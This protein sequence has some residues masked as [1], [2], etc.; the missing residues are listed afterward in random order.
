MKR[1]SSSERLFELFVIEDL[2]GNK[3]NKF[4]K[5]TLIKKKNCAVCNVI[6]KV[7]IQSQTKSNLQLFT[8]VLFNLD[9][10]YVIFSLN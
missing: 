3:R 2:L 6:I 10:L 7:S 1:K 5:K 9:I 8:I 4:V